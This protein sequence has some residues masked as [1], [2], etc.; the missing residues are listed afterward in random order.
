MSDVPYRNAEL[1]ADARTDDLLSRM[2]LREKLAQL[3]GYMFFDTY[4]ETNFDRTEQ[5]RIDYVR[6]VAPAD[7]IPKDGL[8]FIATPVRD[9]PSH[10]AVEVTNRTQDYNRSHTRHGIPVIIHDE[11]V[12]GVIG[13]GTTVFPSA[14]GMAAAWNPEL[15][16]DV[17]HVIGR[18]AKL[19]GINQLLSPTLNLGRDPRN[20]RTEETYGEDPHLASLFATAFVRGVQSEGVICTPK[21][22]V[23][24]FEGDGGRDSEAAEVSERILRELYL[25]PFER[26]IRDAK[27]WSLMPAYNSLNGRPCSGNRWLLTDWLR[28]EAGFE[29]YAVSDYHSVIHQWELHGTARDMG[30]A[31]RQSLEAGLEVELPRLRT[32]SEPLWNEIQSGRVSEDVIHEAAR[33][34]LKPRFAMG[35][36]EDKSLDANEAERTVNCNKHRELAREMARQS[37]VLLRNENHLLPLGNR[38]KR[39]AVVGPN[40]DSIELGDYSW[41][42]FTKEHVVTVYEGIKAAAPIGTE[43][44][45]VSIEE[46]ADLESEDIRIKV[47]EAIEWCDVCITVGGLSHR[48]TR[49]GVDRR[50]IALPDEQE[51]IQVLCKKEKPL[52]TVLLSGSIVINRHHPDALLNCWYPG[53][54]GGT[55]IAEILFGAVAPT[56]RLPLTI[57]KETGY[58]P[59]CYNHKPS[60]RGFKYATGVEHPFGYGMTYTAFDYSDLK[61]NV[62]ASGTAKVLFTLTNAGG[63]A[64]VE[65]PQLYI[66]DVLASV[67]RPLKELKDF[68]RVTL[69]PGESKRVKLAVKAENLMLWNERMERVFEPGDFDIMVGASSEDIRLSKRVVMN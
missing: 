13:N 50:S 28:G 46:D 63:V 55:A 30:D 26:C 22:F 42:L 17:A 5:E 19:R 21:H 40:A 62:S 36:F 34:V 16:E 57:P 59:F 11:G 38:F 7:M 32:F 4:W 37:I 64:G 61:V 35:F 29:G 54:E 12:H 23:V 14:L 33:R 44:R 24:N 67:A 6:S 25:P 9:L 39:I 52:I 47:K 51:L 69:Q 41:D 15:F 8:G 27:P 60:G 18:E 10:I 65:V 68:T 2:T 56:G 20:G 49:E 45:P 43:V 53:E 3:S 48:V 66:H 31:A 58:L 1:T